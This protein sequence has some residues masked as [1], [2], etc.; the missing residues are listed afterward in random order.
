MASVSGEAAVQGATW[1]DSG[2][3]LIQFAREDTL[4]FLLAVLP[5]LIILLLMLVAFAVTVLALFP[6]LSRF[7]LSHYN[8]QRQSSRT[9]AARS[10]GMTDD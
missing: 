9:H 1:A 8:A 4:S 7:F 10:E 6:A 3:A 5:I 2:L